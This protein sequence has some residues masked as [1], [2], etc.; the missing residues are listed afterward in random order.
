MESK[1]QT[2]FIPKKSLEDGGK[3]KVKTPFN[4]FS[5]VSTLL[6]VAAILASAG[7]FGYSFILKKN[8][9]SARAELISKEKRFDYSAVDEIVRVDN[10]LKAAS[11]LVRTH[12]AVTTVFRYLQE[13]TL[14][15][16]RFDDFSFSAVSPSR[17]SISMR[18]KARSFGAVAKQAELF[19]ASSTGAYFTDPVFSD[20]NL[21]EKGNVSFSFITSVDPRLL[22]YVRA[23]PAQEPAFF[24]P[25][26]V[27][28][29]EPTLDN[30][31]IQ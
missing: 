4:I 27:Q 25:S 17:V 8:I 13:S 3:V 26:P 16:L 31:P 19:S 7:A 22:S 20:L 9:S 24:A 21:D 18:G 28:D 14:R 15:N 11:D 30:P 1:F 29:P 2:S 5:L 12:T 10:K 23:L 6:I